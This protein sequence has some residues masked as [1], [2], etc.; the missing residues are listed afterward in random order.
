MAKK[1][2]SKPK[3]GGGSKPKAKPAS[4]GPGHNL[5]VDKA[6]TKTAFDRLDQ[7]HKDKASDASSY[8]SKI[9]NVYETAANDLG[10]TQK[11][12]KRAYSRHVFEKKWQSSEKEMDPE[13]VD[14]VDKLILASASYKTMPLFKAGEDRAALHEA[15]KDTATAAPKEEKAEA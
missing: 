6:G 11:A 5:K 13:V 8:A 2:T 7:L 15:V 1:A 14:Q 10:V 4:P 12:L 3:G 9:G